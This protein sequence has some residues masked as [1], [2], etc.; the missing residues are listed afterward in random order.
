MGQAGRG[1]GKGH[2]RGSDRRRGERRHLRAELRKIYGDR[3]KAKRRK[4]D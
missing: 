1:T 4:A 2:F 3:R